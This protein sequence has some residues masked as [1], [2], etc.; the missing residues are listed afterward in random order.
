MEEALEPVIVA[1]V[2]LRVAVEPKGVLGLRA[3]TDIASVTTAGPSGSSAAATAYLSC[4]EGRQYSGVEG[5]MDDLVSFPSGSDHGREIPDNTR[6]QGAPVGKQT[7]HKDAP[8]ED[9]L[10]SLD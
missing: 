7:L 9:L 10:I 3:P 6:L 2:P 8:E 1:P 4:V 5:W